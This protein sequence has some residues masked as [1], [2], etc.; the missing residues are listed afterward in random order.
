MT[1]ELPK[2]DKTKIVMRADWVDSKVVIKYANP[3]DLYEHPNDGVVKT[4][5]ELVDEYPKWAASLCVTASP[6]ELKCVPGGPS[7]QLNYY[8]C[9]GPTHW[10]FYNPSAK[11]DLLTAA[12]HGYVRP[13]KLAGAKKKSN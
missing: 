7:N 4:L 9:S 6:A 5:S 8:Y 10:E 11:K 3:L 1:E 12:E 13:D 2:V